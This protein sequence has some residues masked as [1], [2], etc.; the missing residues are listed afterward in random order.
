MI[1]TAAAQGVYA[2]G[3]NGFFTSPNG[4]E[5]WIVYHAWDATLAARQLCIDPLRWTATGP[6]T[7]GPSWQDEPLPD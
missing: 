3:H 1:A 5:T 6:S 7:P 4:R 2:P